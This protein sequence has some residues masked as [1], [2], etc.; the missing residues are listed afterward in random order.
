MK[1]NLLTAP[2]VLAGLAVGIALAGN[3]RAEEMPKPAPELAK[4]DWMKGSWKCTG[5]SPAGAM[6]PGSPESKHKATIKWGRALNDF[7]GLMQYEQAKDKANPMPVKAQG[8][9]N[10]DPGQKKFTA[11]GFDSFGGV[12]VV[13]A[14]VDDGGN[15]SAMGEQHMGG[16]KIPYRESITRKGDKEFGVKGEWKMPGADW[17][18]V[19]DDTC[20]K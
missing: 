17:A 3:A 18:V 10:W 6:G 16:Q 9:V 2:V 14:T 15:W 11:Y 19:F 8:M 20:K 12:S 7:W 1:L 5:T 13:T 4:L